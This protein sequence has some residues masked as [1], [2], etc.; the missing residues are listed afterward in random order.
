MASPF[1]EVRVSLKTIVLAERETMAGA[2]GSY[3]THMNPLPL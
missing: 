3:D 1:S 2:V